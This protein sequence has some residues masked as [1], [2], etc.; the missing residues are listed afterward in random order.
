MSQIQVNNLSFCYDGGYDAVF[1]NVSFIL[2]TNWRTGLIGRNGRGKTTMLKLF[3]GQ[4]AYVGSI[5]HEVK[6]D[7]FPFEVEQPE[8]DTLA[9]MKNSIAP[10]ELWEC[11]MERLLTL[12]TGDALHEYAELQ[13]RYLAADGYVIESL[14]AQEIAKLSLADDVLQRPFATLSGGEQTR[15]LLAA[16]FLKHNNFLLLDEPTN[17]LDAHGQDEVARYLAGK[18]GFILASHDRAL[19]DAATDH[20]L[21][22]NKT[23]V[24]VENGNYSV[25]QENKDRRDAFELGENARLK[26]E[27]K[28]LSAAASQKAGWSDKLEKTKIGGEKGGQVA[29]DRGFVG[30]KAAKAMKRAKVIEQHADRAVREKQGLLKN[31]EEAPALKLMPLVYHGGK[32]VQAAG[33]AICYDGKALFTGLNFTVEQG[34]RVALTG[35]NGCG[36]S[37]ILRLIMGEDVPHEGSFLRG[38]GLVISYVPQKTPP[39]CGSLGQFAAENG[40]DESLFKSILR[41][42]DFTRPQLEKDMTELSEGQKRKVLLAKSLCTPAHLYIWDEPFNFIDILSRVQIEELILRSEPTMIFVE[43]DRRFTENTATKTVPVGC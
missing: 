28:K 29:P 9:V 14:I 21:F 26:K 19:L 31:L 8:R 1:E 18:K 34:E 5:T 6:F 12:G 43:H 13:E 36:K 27:I 10:F 42:L 33:L 40:L 39:L 41:K 2:D 30:H 15:A 24:D 35:G 3:L 32:P 7:Y 37:S 16:L 38:S 22:I 23:G 11:E 25:W 20:T 17:H 4:Y